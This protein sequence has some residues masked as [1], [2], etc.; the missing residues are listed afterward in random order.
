MEAEAAAKAGTA[1]AVL[2]VALVG[3]RV[4]AA[5]WGCN[6]KARKPRGGECGKRH[7][8]FQLPLRSNRVL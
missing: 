5:E 8:C 6:S 1:A 4:V 7:R 3:S 2:L